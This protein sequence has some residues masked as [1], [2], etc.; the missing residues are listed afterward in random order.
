MGQPFAPRPPTAPHSPQWEQASKQFT[1]AL[2]FARSTD[3][4]A[5]AVLLSN[6]SAALCRCARMQA[7]RVHAR[8]R[9][10]CGP[11]AEA[12]G[13]L[14]SCTGLSSRAKPHAPHP[15]AAAAHA[16]C[17]APHGLTLRTP[18]PA[19]PCSWS[20]QLRSRPAALSESRA[21]YAP[22]P[23]HL[24]QLAL[25]DADRATQLKPTWH[26]GYSRQARA[27][28]GGRGGGLQRQPNSC[29]GMARGCS[30]PLPPHVSSHPRA[31]ATPLSRNPHAVPPTPP[32]PSHPQ[33]AALFL[34][35]RYSEAEGAYL[36][37]LML[38]PGS[39][40]LAEGLAKVGRAPTPSHRAAR[41][42]ALE[43]GGPQAGRSAQVCGRTSGPL[44]K[45]PCPLV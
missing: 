1:L 38:E 43:A 42:A 24:A 21:L 15:F 22:D 12:A 32:P 14:L 27:A 23:T 9:R 13:S 29:G 26:K 19:P 35:E 39:A 8:Q 31:T 11:H 5:Q 17:S 10:A 6:R 33:G 28:E 25:K 40:T 18:L 30:P 36:E 3:K 2:K 7:L 45:L 4:E 44:C 37:G 20:M 34:L 41:R 16:T